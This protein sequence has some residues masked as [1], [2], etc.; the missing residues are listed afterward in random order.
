MRKSIG[1]RFWD[2][3]DVCGED[4]CWEWKGYRNENGY[5]KMLAFGEQMAHRV[6]WIINSGEI[7]EGIKVLHKCDNPPCVNPEHLFLGTLGDNNK[8]RHRKGRTVVPD[9]KG[10]NH[11]MSKLK[12]SDVVEILRLHQQGLSNMDIVRKFNKVHKATVYDVIFRRTWSHV[13]A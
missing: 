13:Q 5:G 10:S 7:P 8:D 9:N 12:E 1:N 4:E 2:R 11:G 6:S 3:V